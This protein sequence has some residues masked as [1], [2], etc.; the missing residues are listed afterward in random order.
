[1]YFIFLPRLSPFI[2]IIILAL[3]TVNAQSSG[4]GG[5]LGVDARN[6]FERGLQN[7]KRFN[8]SL[9][10][11]VEYQNNID[12]NYYN[13]VLFGRYDSEDSQ[14]SHID[15]REAYWTHVSDNWEMKVGVSKVFWGVTESRHLVDVI[16]QTDFVE[17]IDGEDKLGQPMIKFSIERDWGNLDVFWLPYFRERTFVGKDGRLNPLPYIADIDNAQY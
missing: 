4:F 3:F 12:S 6:F 17:N 1:M 2:V 15:L 9:R 7:Q 13:F 10:G 11:E 16:N 5:E 14:R 8:P